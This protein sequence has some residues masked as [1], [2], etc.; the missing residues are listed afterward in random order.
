M[1]QWE[2]DLTC[3]F[4]PS[5][6]REGRGLAAWDMVAWLWQRVARSGL[7]HPSERRARARIL[8]LLRAVPLSTVG[9]SV[10]IQLGSAGDLL[11]RWDTPG[12]L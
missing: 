1:C 10:C 5:A 3:Q 11:P 12:T 7:C 2:A 4:P 6:R 9:S 8:L